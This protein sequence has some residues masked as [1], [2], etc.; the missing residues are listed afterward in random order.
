MM[1]IVHCATTH[2][3]GD[4]RIFLKE[5]RTLARAGFRVSYIVPHDRDEVIDG[6]QILAVPRPS[7]RPRAAD[8]DRARRVPPGAGA[9]A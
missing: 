5:C 3:A 8:A 6:V 4:P 9:G 2:R 1:H 7:W